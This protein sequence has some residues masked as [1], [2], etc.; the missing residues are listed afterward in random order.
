MRRSLFPPVLAHFPFA[1]QSPKDRSALAGYNTP[2]AMVQ[3]HHK[4]NT[5]GF[6]AG[7][8]AR[9]CLAVQIS[10]HWSKSWTNPA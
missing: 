6:A 3:I 10:D 8:E 5:H 4:R 1:E 9:L 2:A 7:C